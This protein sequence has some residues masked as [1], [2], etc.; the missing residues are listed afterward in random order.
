MSTE[1]L[2]ETVSKIMME[3]FLPGLI[4]MLIVDG[5]LDASRLSEVDYIFS[6][7]E[8]NSELAAKLKYFVSIDDDFLESARDAIAANR[9]EVALVLIA[10]VV[11][12]QLNMFYR[13]ALSECNGQLDE[14]DITRVIKSS[15]L[16]D[17]TGWLFKFVLEDE[18]DNRL[19][20]KL[21]NLAELRNQIVHYKA[22]PQS[23]DDE[24]GG[25]RNQIRIKISGLNFDE[26]FETI[27]CLSRALEDGLSRLRLSTDDYKN[28]QKAMQVIQNA[29]QDNV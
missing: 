27:R 18:L 21:R 26:I 14:D 10:T 25:S 2:K 8:A 5:T 22:I 23:M 28:T 20:N 24:H 17:K 3:K 9:P 12:H 15:Q 19:Q 11:E 13:E 16:A 7:V 6:V 4:R 1:D 29:L